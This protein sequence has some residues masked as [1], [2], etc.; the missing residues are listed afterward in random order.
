MN[1][2][3]V[4]ALSG[5]VYVA[6][7]AG[8]CLAGEY[9]FATLMVLLAALGITELTRLLSAGTD[10]RASVGVRVLDILAPALLIIAMFLTRFSFGA[11]CVVFGLLYVTLRMCAAVAD[12]R[13]GQLHGVLTSFAAMAYVAFPLFMLSTAYTLAWRPVA[14]VLGMFVFIWM[15]DTFAYLTG[16]FLGKHKMCQRLSPKKT[17][18]GFW[19]GFLFCV[20]AGALWGYWFDGVADRLWIWMLYAALCSLA[21]TVG[22]LFESLIKRSVG[23]KDSGNIIPGH[24]GI[25]DRIDSVLA[26]APLALIFAF[27]IQ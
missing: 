16:R 12:K 7:I 27:I 26:A 20:G 2:M 9:F 8:C 19:G 4:R 3:L 21:G 24:G 1:N 10:Y 14:L 25:L 11:G 13:A 15:N 6:L 5:A 23:V 18:E 17:I 22:D